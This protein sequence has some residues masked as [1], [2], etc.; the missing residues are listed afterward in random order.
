MGE[1]DQNFTNI[2]CFV[3]YKHCPDF[4]APICHC[5]LSRYTDALL[6]DRGG[7]Q[8]LELRQPGA[9]SKVSGI[10]YILW[11]IHWIYVGGG[12]ILL[13]VFRKFNFLRK[14]NPR[15]PLKIEKKRLSISFQPFI[16]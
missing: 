2:Q 3:H 12:H 5:P 11:N 16:G 8:D 10:H 15:A 6:E 13:D 14:K 7:E 9:P 1:I 4:K